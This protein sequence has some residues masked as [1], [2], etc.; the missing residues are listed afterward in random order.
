MSPNPSFAFDDNKY[1]TALYYSRKSS[2]IYND[3]ESGSK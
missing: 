2:Q 3:Y 1:D